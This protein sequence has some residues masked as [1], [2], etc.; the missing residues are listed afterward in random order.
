[1]P[2]A[3]S[4]LRQI[5]FSYLMGAPLKA[6]V[7][8]QALAAKTTV[9]FIEKVGFKETDPD[10]NS[11]FSNLAADADGGDVRYVTFEYVK[12]DEDGDDK[13]VSLKVPFLTIV[14]VPFLR[15]DEVTVDFTAKLTD[16]IASTTKQNF[17]LATDAKGKF[18]A[19]WSPLSLEM[20]TSMSYQNS[21]ETASKFVREYTMNIEMR[22]VQDDMPA[23][24]ER[25][26]DLLEQT[27]Q[28]KPAATP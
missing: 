22:A 20:R 11:L 13:T 6:A 15:L 26:L 23:G 1:M 16:T 17:K 25:I 18:K 8:A 9:E 14:P 2:R 10:I 21:R 27:I 4:E 5:P 7:E 28:E 19:W 12:V 24:M 3:V